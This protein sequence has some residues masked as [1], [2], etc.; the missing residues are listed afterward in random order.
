MGIRSFD[1]FNRF[2]KL[3]RS[4]MVNKKARLE[5]RAGVLG[6]IF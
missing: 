1:S 3:H 5:N 6:I 4:A 2:K